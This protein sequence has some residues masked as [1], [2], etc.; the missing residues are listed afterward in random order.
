MIEDIDQRVGDFL[1]KVMRIGDPRGMLISE[2]IAR[3]LKT[4]GVPVG[5]A[6]TKFLSFTLTDKEEKEFRQF[7]YKNRLPIFITGDTEKRATNI[8]FVNGVR[9]PIGDTPFA[10]FLRLVVELFKNKKGMVSKSRLINAGYIKAD[11]EFQA[12]SRL[13]QAFNTSLDGLDPKDFIEAC[14]PKFLRLSTHPAL[15]SYD[16]EKLLCHRNNK[17]KRLTERLP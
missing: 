5:S 4:Y 17:I 6:R 13:R 2:K 16:K 7:S 10:L 9:V 14:Q 12:I 15:I 3:N 1:V 11:G 8:V